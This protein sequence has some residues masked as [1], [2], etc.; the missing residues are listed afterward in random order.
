MNVLIIGGGGREQA[1]AGEILSLMAARGVFASIDIHNNTGLNPH[2]GCINKLD[3][4]FMHLAAMFSRITVYFIRPTGVQSLGGN[5][6]PR[7]RREP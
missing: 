2:Y 5:P 4:A 6:T 3:H 1:M 7:M